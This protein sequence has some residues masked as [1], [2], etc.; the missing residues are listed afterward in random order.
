MNTT[1]MPLEEKYEIAL[2]TLERCFRLFRYCMYIDDPRPNDA[3]D[4]I[5]DA[6]KRLE[7]N[8]RLKELSQRERKDA[9][10]Y[11]GGEDRIND[12]GRFL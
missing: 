10:E 12:D 9:I 2:M 1:E 5:E 11:C 4:L 8:N 3:E 6:L 7:S